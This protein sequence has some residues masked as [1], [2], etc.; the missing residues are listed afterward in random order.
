MSTFETWFPQQA[1]N[2]HECTELTRNAKTNFVSEINGAGHATKSD[3]SAHAKRY[4]RNHKF[5]GNAVVLRNNGETLGRLHEWSKIEELTSRL[6]LPSDKVASYKDNVR[7][8]NMDRLEELLDLLQGEA[9]PPVVWCF[10]EPNGD[11][12][13]RNVNLA[14]LPCRL[15]LPKLDKNDYLPLEIDVPT[16]LP[17]RKATAFDGAFQ[18][19]WSPGGLSCP[20]NEC[21]GETGLPEVIV[22]GKSKD[23]V[24]GLTYRHAKVPVVS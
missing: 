18:E 15:G 8:G 19:Y 10:R 1:K 23:H 20:R 2:I 13:F 17:A 9:M 4:F 6:R 16:D 3:M 7:V 5:L 11:A 22:P 12:P 24:N 21:P 14:L